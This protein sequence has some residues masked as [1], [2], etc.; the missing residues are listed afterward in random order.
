M[1]S[2][3]RAFL[4]ATAGFGLLAL[5]VFRPTANEF[6][7]T[8]PAFQGLVGDALLLVWATSHVSRQLFADP[9]H[10]FDAGIFFPA[11]D[12][13]AYGDHMI[14]QAL[15]GLPVWLATGN[16]LL[17]YNLLS[18]ASFALGGAA[19][20]CYARE[21]VGGTAAGVAAGIVFAFTPF[22][23]HSPLWLQVLFTPFMPLALF[24]WRRF[25][26]RLRWRDWALW[27][28]CWV[29]HSL[30][31]MYL[32]LYFAI[33]MGVLA[34]LSLLL[35]PARRTIRLWA[36]TLLGPL[37]AAALVAPTLWPY[38][39]LRQLQG[40]LRQVGLDTQLSFFL[41][42]PGT[43]TGSLL[44]L[45]GPAQFGPGLVVVVLAAVGILVGWRHAAAEGGMRRFLWQAHG[46]GLALTLL[47]VSTPI[48][49]QLAL[50]GF[51]MTRNS[52]RAFFVSLLF[53]ALFA[54]EAVG[55]AVRRARSR[56]RRMLL[57]SVLVL[58]VLAD[59]G[60][61]PRERKRLPLGDEILPAYRWLRSLPAGEVVYDGVNG[62]E[63]I[64]LA[65]YHS[66]FHQKR[67]PIG[68]S[69]FTSPGGAYVTQ[70]LH[71]FPD[72]AAL[73]L[74]A[75]LG[76]RHVLWHFRDPPA[77]EAFIAGRLPRPWVDVAAPFGADV[78]FLVRDA[79]PRPPT[80]AV[81]R[82]L[83][84]AGWRLSA[85]Q[86]GETLGA[87]TDGDPRSAWRGQAGRDEPTPWLLVDLGAPEPVAGVRCVP[88]APHAPG[89][90]LALPEVSLDGERWEPTGAAF[91]PDSLDTL[92]ERPLALTYYEARFPTRTVRWVRLVNPELRFWGGT[93][94]IAELDVLTD[95]GE[96]EGGPP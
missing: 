11:R 86:G 24:F 54:A 46:A 8:L 93:W 35:S 84:R 60:A 53:L 56:G 21:A 66:I 18:L 19:A 70:R 80:P 27:V 5:A 40:H 29:A 32:A 36:G 85:S 51:D 1:P 43:L 75:R 89:V 92:I 31:G 55:W 61:P 45:E 23:F 63:Q 37:A 47:I 88:L 83:P 96:A 48:R 79:P 77:A 67:L 13:L 95:A 52:N 65:M 87:L 58:L 7:H 14:G 69:G 17:E 59:T 78:V 28:A 4:A 49:L 91:E 9:L 76:I 71:R 34:L 39:Q 3:A 6:A 10:L 22:R 20:F 82:A 15:A 12:T 64:A 94:E 74:L 33:T 72:P 73:R 68:Y 42:G 16:P 50:P 30:M 62:P 2:S 90:Y 57:G 41:P 26:E 38:L 81:V 25:L 44:G